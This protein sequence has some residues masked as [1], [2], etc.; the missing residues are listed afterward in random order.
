MLL[1]DYPAKREKR[2]TFFRSAVNM[3]ASMLVVVSTKAAT[4]K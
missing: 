1:V 2:V 3:A 4:D